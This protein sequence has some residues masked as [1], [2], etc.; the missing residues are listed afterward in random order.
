MVL[1][2]NPVYLGPIGP[3]DHKNLPRRKPPA[4]HRY[5]SHILRQA[6][7]TANHRANMQQNKQPHLKHQ[8][9]PTQKYSLPTHVQGLRKVLHWKHNTIPTRS[10]E[11][12]FHQPQFVRKKHLI[13]C[14]RNTQNIEAK[15]ITHEND[16]ANLRLCEALFIRK[17][18]PFGLAIYILACLRFAKIQKRWLDQTLLMCRRSVPK[19]TIRYI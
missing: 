7:H 5:K 1:S 4:T 6:R 8:S 9:I 19:G 18:K 14:H 17:H 2:Q 10:C 13:M 3:R 16:P 15:I 12:T 11:R